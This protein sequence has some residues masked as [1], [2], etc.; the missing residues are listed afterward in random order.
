LHSC[1]GQDCLL[2][3]ASII[4]GLLQGFMRVHGSSHGRRAEVLVFM[5]SWLAYG[6]ALFNRSFSGAAGG[7]F[8]WRLDG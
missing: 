4:S 3:A 6:I 7:S 8:R 5:T 2:F 1:I